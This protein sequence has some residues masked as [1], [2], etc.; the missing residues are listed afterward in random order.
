MNGRLLVLAFQFPERLAV[1]DDEAS[2]VVLPA[3]AVGLCEVDL[4]SHC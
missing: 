2:V 4:P 1:E 3:Q